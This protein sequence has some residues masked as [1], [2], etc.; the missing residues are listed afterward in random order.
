MKTLLSFVAALLLASCMSDG[1]KPQDDHDDHGRAEAVHDDHDEPK[2]EHGVV[3]LSPQGVAAARIKVEPATAGRLTPTLALPGRIALDPRKE[4]LVSAWIAGQV[5]AIAVR[6]GDAV[7]RGGLLGTVQSPELGE[8]IAA[9]R[10]ARARDQAADARLERLQRLE[11]QGVSS[12]SQVLEADAAHSEAEGAL[13]A[14]EERL[15][16]LGVDPSVGDPH[17]GE[18][19]VSHVPVRSPI[20]GKVLGTNAAVG[21]NVAPGETLFHIGDLSQVWLLVDV[22]EADL[23]RVMQDQ[24]VAFT[25]AAWPGE[26]FQ[27]TVEQVG[28]WVEPEARTIEVRVL[29]DNPDGRLKP[30]MFA[31]ATLS[32]EATGAASGVV[33]P[34]DAITE[35]DGQPVVFVQTGEG[36]FEVRT[37]SITERS[38]TQALLTAG[39]EP[40]ELVVVDGAFALKS[41]LEKGELGEGHAH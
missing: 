22:Y 40:G 2:V 29:V 10:S 36:H 38:A 7:R 6:P 13:E 4:A 11:T 39:A 3:E 1:P 19:Y 5:D 16:I 25:V 35:L 18:H 34:V 31:S 32:V 15:R 9:Y 17:E 24:P 23:G 20:A 28:D 12:R 37:I 21:R 41:E 30:N 14:A 27:G 26:T 33:L 8:A